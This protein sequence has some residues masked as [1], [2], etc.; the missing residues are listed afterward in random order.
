MVLLKK[1][2][3]EGGVIEEDIEEV[4]E[5]E[6]VDDILDHMERDGVCQDN[7][8]GDITEGIID[9]CIEAGII[10]IRYIIIQRI[11]I[12]SITY[13]IVW[14]HVDLDM[15]EYLVLMHVEEFTEFDDQINC[16]NVNIF[17]HLL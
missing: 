13:L 4:E 10:T 8:G 16:N 2:L 9:L 3:E 6:E 1:V 12:Q 7:R 11:I 5:V 14:I 15:I 17:L